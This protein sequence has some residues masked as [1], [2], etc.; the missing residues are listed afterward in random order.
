MAPCR[1]RPWLQQHPPKNIGKQGTSGRGRG[2]V[3][4]G[5]CSARTVEGFIRGHRFTNTLRDGS[6]LA[7]LGGRIYSLTR[8]RPRPVELVLWMVLWMAL[9]M[10]L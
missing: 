9:C 1:H 4:G 2:P 8:H 7:R 6:S 10:A 3:G 5:E